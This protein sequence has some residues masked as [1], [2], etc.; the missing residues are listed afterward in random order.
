MKT[1]L[2]DHSS[3]N[4][5]PIHG[6]VSRDDDFNQQSFELV[7][8]SLSIQPLNSTMHSLTNSSFNNSNIDTN[9]SNNTNN[10][11]HAINAKNITVGPTSMFGND[12]STQQRV[13]TTLAGTDHDDE[14]SN[15]A[16]DITLPTDLMVS[17]MCIMT[18][19]SFSESEK[20]FVTNETTNNHTVNHDDSESFQKETKEEGIKKTYS[21]DM[22][23]RSVASENSDGSG[24][25]NG[26]M[27][28][29]ILN[30]TTTTSSSQ[31]GMMNNNHA[32]TNYYND[33]YD[34][35]MIMEDSESAVDLSTWNMSD[36]KDMSEMRS[37]LRKLK[38]F[39]FLL[40]YK[41]ICVVYALAFLFG[42]ILWFVAGGIEEALYNHNSDSNN[43]KRIFLLDGGILVFDRG[44]GMSTNSILII[45]LESIVY[46]IVEAV[47]LII[48]FFVDRDTWGIKK[49][50]IALI[51]IQ[52]LSAILFIILGTLEVVQSLVDY[53]VPYGFVLWGYMFLEIIV[54]VTL[55]LLYA[56]R[57]DIKEEEA[58]QERLF[59]SKESGL[60][61][62]LKNKK[63][64]HL[65]LDFA[66][67]SFAPESV[68]CWRDIQRFKNSKRL[69]RKKAAMHI[70]NAYLTLGAPLELNMPH[71]EEK[72]QELLSMIEKS[73]KISPNLFVTIQDHCLN[74]MADL[75]ERLKN[76]NKEIAEIVNKHRRI[77]ANQKELN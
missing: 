61:K 76:L 4:V 2:F 55:P 38:I 28:G 51:L 37:E 32:T 3:S 44:C 75:F 57:S 54:A 20:T 31:M 24:I 52:V 68:Q 11:N 13:A 1:K 58:R 30:P 53:Y 69:N 34:T 26:A 15:V 7:S 33:E 72:R 45:G 16:V 17:G 56:I 71:I 67:R 73:E 27:V 49:E 64:F 59:D 62:I 63:T 40:S 50:T 10:T 29:F 43:R 48:T 21:S 35:E 60:E 18:N 42:I 14:I 39:N 12:D 19:V 36:Y 41:F 74:D 77:V 66:R 22:A 65:M 9:N 8:S 46:I 25:G 47:F 70:L 5:T 6:N 23:H